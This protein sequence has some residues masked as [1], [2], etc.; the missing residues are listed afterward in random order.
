MIVYQLSPRVQNVDFFLLFFSTELLVSGWAFVPVWDHGRATVWVP[1]GKNISIVF[2]SNVLKSGCSLKILG[3]IQIHSESACLLK[4]TQ[5]NISW[6]NILEGTEMTV[7]RFKFKD[8]IW[9]KLYFG[10][11]NWEETPENRFFFPRSKTR[12]LKQSTK[13]ESSSPKHL[14]FLSQISSRQV[15]S[16]GVHYSCQQ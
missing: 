1:E 2:F 15:L 5:F 4:C 14:T 9:Q 10:K 8:V 12:I 16:G 13:P 11:S 7:E 3:E 6:R